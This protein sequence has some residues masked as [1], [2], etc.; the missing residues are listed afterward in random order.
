[1]KLIRDSLDIG[2]LIGH[3]QASP[4]FDKDLLGLYSMGTIPALLE[5]IYWLR[6]GSI[7]CATRAHRG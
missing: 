7:E 3:I 2:L 1:M 6:F 5:S 4:H